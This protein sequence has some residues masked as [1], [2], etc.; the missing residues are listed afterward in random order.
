MTE[1]FEEKIKQKAKT[2]KEIKKSHEK[3]FWDN[4]QGKEGCQSLWDK[5][6]KKKEWIH[7]DDVLK[8]LEG[9]IVVPK[10]KVDILLKKIKGC[11]ESQCVLTSRL[12]KCRNPKYGSKEC[13]CFLDFEAFI[14]LLFGEQK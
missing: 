11:N 6:C 13:P 3:N 12:L 9:K 2:V 4:F 14:E 10:Q 8:I 7:K 1:S 5:E